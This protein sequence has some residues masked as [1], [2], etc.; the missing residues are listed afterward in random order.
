M[1]SWLAWI[2]CPTCDRQL[3]FVTGGKAT[4][5]GRRI[6]AIFECRNCGTE[7][8]LVATLDRVHYPH[9]APEGQTALDVVLRR[10]A[11]A[12][13]VPQMIE[14]TGLGKDAVY[15]ACKRG[16]DKGAL[17]CVGVNV[18]GRQTYRRVT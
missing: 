16:V 10:A 13:T 17:E 18:E 5:E 9:R 11:G 2:T 4:D 6:T 12:F 14:T 1:T 8:H 3:S 7:E 15:Q